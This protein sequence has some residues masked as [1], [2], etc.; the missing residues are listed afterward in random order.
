MS[1][2]K[3]SLAETVEKKQQAAKKAHDGKRSK[4][5][6]FSPGQQVLIR[7]FR[8]K[9]KWENG[10]ILQAL[11]PVGYIVQTGDRHK[12]VHLDH[13]IDGTS[14]QPDQSTLT[15]EDIPISFQSPAL[16]AP[17]QPDAD[18]QLEGEERVELAPTPDV[19]R[20]PLRNRRPP[21]RWTYE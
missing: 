14:H 2:I 16:D 7:S 13:I 17:D 1:L 20:F 10:M 5:R 19:R 4:I 18:V 8:G 11:G 9:D 6:Q 15:D 3:P 12:H 21:D